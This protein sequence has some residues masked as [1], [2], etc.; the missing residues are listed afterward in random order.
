MDRN[1]LLTVGEL[2]DLEERLYKKIIDFLEKTQPQKWI[3]TSELKDILGI[4]DSSIQS[5]RNAGKLPYSKIGGSYYYNY[6]EVIGL[7]E[8]NKTDRMK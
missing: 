7:L 8:E 6:E 3:R 2:Y 5:L 1:E 4:S